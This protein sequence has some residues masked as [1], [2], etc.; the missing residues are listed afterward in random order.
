MSTAHAG[1]DLHGADCGMHSDYS[2]SIK[3]DALVFTRTHGAPSDIVISNGSLRV[4]GRT[5]DVSAADRERLLALE[6]GVRDTLPEIKAI[7]HEAISIAFDAVG[8]VAA[9]FAKDGD[10]ARA[11]AQRLARTAA[12]LNLRID[13]SDNF[14]GWNDKDVERLVEG[15]VGTLVGEV[16]GNV[17]G[18]AISVALSG[19]EKA[20]AE[21]EARAN[22][23]DKNVERVVKKRSRDLEARVVGMC[24]RLHRLAQLEGEL[25]VRLAD[26]SRLDLVSMR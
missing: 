21:L 19:D 12:D 8:E 5:L 2:L 10:A 23:I 11:S 4:D 3:P 17:A 6:H 16:V 24:P 25:D 9:A 22:S 26:G 13:A 15:A 14:A 7:A 20:A 18:Q 1:M